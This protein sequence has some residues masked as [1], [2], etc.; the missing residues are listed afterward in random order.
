M[1]ACTLCINRQ[2]KARHEDLQHTTVLIIKLK[3]KFHIHGDCSQHA[4]QLVC[5]RH[6]WK[7]MPSYIHACGLTEKHV[8]LMDTK[9][10]HHTLLNMYMM[11]IPLKCMLMQ[12]PLSACLQAPCQCQGSLLVSSPA[13]IIHCRWPRLTCPR[14][15]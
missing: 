6:S 8:Q 1:H 13:G 2:V 10:T 5:C 15:D 11:H 4:H 3:K 9:T 12:L 7:D 14:A